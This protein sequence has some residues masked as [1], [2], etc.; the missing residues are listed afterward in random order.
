MT[1]SERW[2]TFS[3]ID[4]KNAASLVPEVLLYDPLVIPVPSD[5]NENQRWKELG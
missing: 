4:H 2:G 1:V 3:V 5:D